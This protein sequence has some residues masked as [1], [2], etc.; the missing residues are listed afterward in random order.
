MNSF[1]ILFL[2]GFLALTASDFVNCNNTGP[3]IYLDLAITCQN[4]NLPIL[5]LHWNPNQFEPSALEIYY[6]NRT[7]LLTNYLR[8]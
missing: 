4:P 3:D 8:C 7:K 5:A 2:M 6:C 1:L